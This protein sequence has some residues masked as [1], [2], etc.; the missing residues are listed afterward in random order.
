MSRSKKA[1]ATTTAVATT[2]TTPAVTAKEEVMENATPLIIIDANGEKVEMAYITVMSLNG[3]FTYPINVNDLNEIRYAWN[4]NNNHLK[5][6]MESN[7]RSDG[8]EKSKKQADYDRDMGTRSVLVDKLI[9]TIF[10]SIPLP[11]RKNRYKDLM[12]RLD[13]LSSDINGPKPDEN[14]VTTVAKEM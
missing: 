9:S 1:D 2:A 5:N 7:E 8:K 3:T 13:H 11:E 10:A 14:G 4:I 12:E 6:K